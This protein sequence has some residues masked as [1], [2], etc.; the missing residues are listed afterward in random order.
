MDKARPLGTAAAVA[1][2]LLLTGFTGAAQP[3]LR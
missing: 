2:L 3:G 1:S